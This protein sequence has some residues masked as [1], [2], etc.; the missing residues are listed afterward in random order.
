MSTARNSTSCR[1]S[2][3]GPNRTI[4][5]KIDATQLSRMSLGEAHVAGELAE[6]A[7]RSRHLTFAQ[8][9]R[10]I[11]G[12]IEAHDAPERRG[13][14][15]LRRFLV[16][17][18]ERGLE[19]MVDRLARDEQAHDLRRPLEDQIDPRVAHRALDRDR[20]LAA[21]AERVGGLVAA[22]AADLQRV[23]DDAP[24]VLGVVHLG[25]RRFQSDVVVPAL[26]EADGEPGDRFHREGVRR[27]HRRPSRDRFVLADRRAPLHA[28]RGPGA[29]RLQQRL[30]PARGARGQREAAG[31][32]RDRA[33][34]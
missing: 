34:A 6:F 4:A 13:L 11:P 1:R 19:V 23:V 29:R 25:D 15:A 31:V 27:H 18:R 26:G 14:L 16:D 10:R 12:R 7:E 32:Q 20:P 33:R 9:A 17:E 8:P 30:A 5:W 22:P 28:L 2:S 21:R 24:P 3:L